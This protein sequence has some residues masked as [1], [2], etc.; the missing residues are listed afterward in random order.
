[1]KMK[2]KKLNWNATRKDVFIVAQLKQ[3]YFR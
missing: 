2:S 3:I 1:M